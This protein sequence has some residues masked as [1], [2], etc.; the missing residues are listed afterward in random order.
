MLLSHVPLFFKN[1]INPIKN[2]IHCLKPLSNMTLLINVP[3]LERP[4]YTT[5]LLQ[6]QSHINITVNTMAK[7]W[8]EEL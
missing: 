5:S 2:M 3:E 1:D 6:T 7:K 4:F 8:V